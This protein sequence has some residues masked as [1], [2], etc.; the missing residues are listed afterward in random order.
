LGVSFGIGT[1]ISVAIESEGVS[2]YATRLEKA[3]ASGRT[4]GNVLY[5]YDKGVQIKRMT[6]DLDGLSLSEKTEL[7][8]FFD[9][10]VNGMELDFVYI[11]E[12]G[13]SWDARFLTPELVW[14][15]RAPELWGVQ[16]DLE[17]W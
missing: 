8:T 13:N 17:V 16:F 7:Q 12:A 5:V 6:V 3:Q 11:D 15:K 1:S 10:T 2:G 4:A 9:T 14:A